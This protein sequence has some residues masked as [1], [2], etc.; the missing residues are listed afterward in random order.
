MLVIRKKNL[1]GREKNE[2]SLQKKIYV[3]KRK[4]TLTAM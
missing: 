1:V 3:Y 4:L 2:P